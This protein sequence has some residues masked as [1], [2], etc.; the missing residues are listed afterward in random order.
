MNLIIRRPDDMHLHLRDGAILKSVIGATA[1]NFGRAI[2]MPNLSPPVTTAAAAIAYRKRILAVLPEFSSF[3]PL[4]TV[5]LTDN[6]DPADVGEAIAGGHISA[7]KLYPA[8]ST[9][10]S[11]SGVTDI[12]RTRDVLAVLAETST[13]LC[14]HGEVSDF[15]VDVFDREKIFID[16]VLEKIVSWEPSLPIVLEHVTTADGIEFVRSNHPQ[17][18]ATITVHHLILNRNH[19]FLGGL[20]PHYYCLPVAKREQHR[21]ALLEAATGR[22]TAFFLGTDSAPH[23]ASDKETSVG[24]AGI[25]T[26]PVALS[27]LAHVFEDAGALQCL[28]EFA[29]ING[30]RFYGLEPSP[31]TVELRKRAAPIPVAHELPVGDDRIIIFDPGFNLYWEVVRNEGIHNEN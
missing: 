17:T 23:L 15:G 26:A 5:Y 21:Q 7:V 20:R 2:I 25:F 4:M 16:R 6:T 24:C 31:E 3:D 13:P 1:S 9:T 8:G 11:Q 10:N 19:M 18:A 30:P 12:E 14:V 28:E 22:E 29:S 27:C